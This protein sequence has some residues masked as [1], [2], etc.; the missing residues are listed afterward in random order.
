MDLGMA[1]AENLRAIQEAGFL[2]TAVSRKCPLEIPAVG[3]VVIKQSEA[4]TIEVKRLK[5]DGEVMLCCRS[6]AQAPKEVQMRSRMQQL[7]EE[8]LGKLAS[9]LSKAHGVKSHAKVLQRLGPLGERYPSIAQFYDI[10]VENHGGQVSRISWEIPK[11]E[12][13]QSL[14]AG[15]YYLGTNR[16]DLGEVEL[17]SLYMMLNQV[18][19]VFRALKSE[20][21]LSTVYH[22]LDPRLAGYLSLSWSIISWPLSSAVCRPRSSHTVG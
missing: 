10:K 8:A 9:G 15:A 13:L 22:R 1:G 12:K 19:D 7:F 4:T 17:C 11:P 18:E 21:A 2:Y 20:I 14:L 5:Q 16:Q 6:W 3:M